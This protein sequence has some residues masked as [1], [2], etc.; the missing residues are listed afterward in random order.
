MTGNLAEAEDAAQEA[1]ARAWQQWH[2]LVALNDPEV[3]VRTVAYRV[4]ISAWRKAAN[5]LIAHRRDMAGRRVPELEPEHVAL[6]EALRGI[7]PNQRRV[8]VLHH[9]VGLSVEEV[10]TEICVSAGTVKSRLARGRAALALKLS[11]RAPPDASAP[12]STTSCGKE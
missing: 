5:R 7:S 3:W 2:R 12:V 1:Y 6:V 9:L 11:D 10:A 8:I 4:A